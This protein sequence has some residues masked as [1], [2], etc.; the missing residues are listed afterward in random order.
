MNHLPAKVARDHPLF[1]R[2]KPR[3]RRI[4]KAALGGLAFFTGTF[5]ELVSF[6]ARGT[7]WHFN[8]QLTGRL[9]IAAGMSVLIWVWIDIVRG[10][11]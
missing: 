1:P 2:S 4:A 7:D 3:I 5:L 11:E 6:F 8:R 9:L 10:D